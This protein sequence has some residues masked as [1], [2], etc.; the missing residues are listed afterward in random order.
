MSSTLSLSPHK[1]PG[2]VSTL[3]CIANSSKKNFLPVCTWNLAPASPSDPPLF[4]L[5]NVCPICAMGLPLP[6]ISLVSQ[7]AGQQSRPQAASPRQIESRIS[8]HVRSRS[9]IAALKTTATAIDSMPLLEAVDSRRQ[10]L[11]L[12]AGKWISYRYSQRRSG[13]LSTQASVAASRVS[14]ITFITKLIRLTS[15]DE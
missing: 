5:T 14:R 2:Q 8:C 13:K 9:Y 6:I 1:Q 3:I 7:L 12:P 15:L 10:L 11:N 4:G